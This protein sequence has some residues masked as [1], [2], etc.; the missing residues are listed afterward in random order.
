MGPQLRKQQAKT[1]SENEE[2]SLYCVRCDSCVRYW[3]EPRSNT[4]QT[5]IVGTFLTLLHFCILIITRL[6][7]VYMSTVD[8]TARNCWSSPVLIIILAACT[9]MINGTIA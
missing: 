6:R 4:V 3:L 9:A 8:G 5:M 2:E 7:Y 1:A